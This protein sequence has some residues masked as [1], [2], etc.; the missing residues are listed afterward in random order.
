M[1]VRFAEIGSS[2]ST[3]SVT[4]RPR[5]LYGSYVSCRT[6]GYT[7]DR[8]RTA[9]SPPA[10]ATFVIGIVRAI[11]FGSESPRGSARAPAWSFSSSMF[12]N[13][14]IRSAELAMSR[15]RHAMPDVR[16][17]HDRPFFLALRRFYSAPHRSA[18]RRS[19]GAAPVRVSARVAPTFP[20]FEQ[21]LRFKSPDKSGPTA[22]ATYLTYSGNTKRPQCTRKDPL[23]SLLGERAGLGPASSK[24]GEQTA[25]ESC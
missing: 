10:T 17:S 2:R 8:A 5:A 25:M 12:E 14:I 3:P 1:R 21:C 9:P 16:C 18:E 20:P 22:R 13:C 6:W 24:Y 19:A 7:G 11:G 15:A 4:P 23:S